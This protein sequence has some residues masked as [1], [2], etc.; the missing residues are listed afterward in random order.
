[1]FT[2]KDASR[3]FITG[4]FS[5]AGLVDDL[6][7]LGS[8]SFN[9]VQ[10]KETLTMRFSSFSHSP[11]TSISLPEWSDFYAQNYRRVGRLVGAFYDQNGCPTGQVSFVEEQLEKAKQANL[12]DQYENELFPPCNLEYNNQKKETR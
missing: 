3:A 5:E 10:G 8:E 11:N 4:D 2:G 7:G 6:S 9:G 12:D 1:M